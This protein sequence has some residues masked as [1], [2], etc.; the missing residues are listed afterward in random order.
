MRL[1]KA[2]AIL[3]YGSCGVSLRKIGKLLNVSN[4]SV[5]NWV[6]KVAEN[7]EKIEIPDETMDAPFDEF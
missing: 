6:R 4:V 1:K 7:L 2:L 5:L 3:L